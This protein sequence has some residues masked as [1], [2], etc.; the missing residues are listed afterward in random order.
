[1]YSLL[2]SD[3]NREN[4][5]G[6]QAHEDYN[7]NYNKNNNHLLSTHYVAA[8]LSMFHR[9]SYLL[10]SVKIRKLKFRRLNLHYNYSKIMQLSNRVNIQ[11]QM[12]L[13]PKT[14]MFLDFAKDLY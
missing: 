5:P 2:N 3:W 8:R 11:T 13:T 6:S 10:P 4:N 7:N 9:L 1:M 12:H 14:T